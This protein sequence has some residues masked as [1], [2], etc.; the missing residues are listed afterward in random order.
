M[1]TPTPAHRRYVIRMA[2]LMGAYLL[3]LFGVTSRFHNG[4][5]DS[6]QAFILALLPGLPIVGVFWA[7]GRL[8]IELNDEFMR[9][10]MVRQIIIAAGF[11]MS[12]A[13]VHGFLSTFEVVSKVDAYWWPVAFFFGLFI[14]QV[15]NYLKYGTWGNCA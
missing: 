9:M 15:A 14:G 2:L 4:G 10:L 8:L 1:F 3:I 6:T 12:I 11:S 5:V 7:I 13:A